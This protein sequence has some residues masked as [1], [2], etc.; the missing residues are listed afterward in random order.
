MWKETQTK[1]TLITSDFV[2]HPQIVIFSVFKIANLSPYLLQ[3]PAIAGDCYVLVVLFMVA[4]C[5]R[6]DDYIFALWFLLLL[7]PSPNLS[8]RRLDV[9][10]TFTH[11]VAL[12][13]N[14]RCRSETCCTRLAENT[15]RK[16]VAKNRHLGT[17]AQIC[18]AISSQLRHVSTIGKKLLAA[19]SPQHVLTIWR[20][21][22]LQ[23]ST[24]FAC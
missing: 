4:L 18:W 1:C 3:S 12:S 15:G 13:A 11:C 23:R 7:F 9:Y 16:N 20:T 22:A 5:N 8:H 2:I 6:A 10:H 17:I 24:G 14:F 21:S 19:I